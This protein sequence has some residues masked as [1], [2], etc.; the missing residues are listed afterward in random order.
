MS[1]SSGWKELECVYLGRMILGE[2]EG[3]SEGEGPVRGWKAGCHAK[4]RG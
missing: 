4:L 2:V 3:S 1:A